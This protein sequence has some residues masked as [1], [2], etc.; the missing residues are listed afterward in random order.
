MPIFQAEQV[1][2]GNAMRGIDQDYDVRIRVW[3]QIPGTSG[4]G[5]YILKELIT[6]RDQLQSLIGDLEEACR[7]AEDM[8]RKS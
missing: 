2:R 3:P 7:S 5:S 6:N 8:L 1:P 4:E